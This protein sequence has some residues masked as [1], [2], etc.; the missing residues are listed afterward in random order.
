MSAQH[1]TDYG[2]RDLAEDGVILVIDMIGDYFQSW[3]ADTPEGEAEEV[4]DAHAMIPKFV[5]M[6]EFARTNNIPI[7]YSAMQDGGNSLLDHHWPEIG[8]G[9]IHVAGSKGSQVI[10][11]LA[12]A[13]FTESEVYL[14]KSNYSCFCETK[15]DTTLRNPPFKGRNSLIITGMATNFCCLATSID[16][17]NRQYEVLFVDDMNWTVPGI[18]G[19]PAAEMHRVTVETLKQGYV[20]AVLSA[21]ELM[22]RLRNSVTAAA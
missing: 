1:A 19:T 8:E 2:Q 22:S 6:L 17:F 4:D 20:E 11:D 5:E 7:V 12:P 15:L 18:D 16:A 14:P 21:D 9:R 10:P 3:H 13:K